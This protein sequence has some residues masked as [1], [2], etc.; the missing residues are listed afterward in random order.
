MSRRHVTSKRT[1]SGLHQFAVLH[2]N[3]ANAAL[4][5]NPS[6]LPLVQANQL[7]VPLPHHEQLAI[8][9]TPERPLPRQKPP[10][11]RSRARSHSALPQRATSATFVS[12]EENVLSLAK[13]SHLFTVNTKDLICLHCNTG[14]LS[15]LFTFKLHFQLVHN[16][17]IEGSPKPQLDSTSPF[18]TVNRAQ[19]ADAHLSSCSSPSPLELPP[20]SPSP[21][22][23]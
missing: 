8:F 19:L 4:V 16:T 9:C 20:A 7:P 14:K 3:R 22:S 23:S 12:A 11:L 21:N 2:R 10:Q 13:L 1:I 15:K 6:V 18:S 17:I 5:L